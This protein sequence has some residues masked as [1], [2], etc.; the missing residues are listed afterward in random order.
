MNDNIIFK[1]PVLKILIMAT[2]DFRLIV[3]NPSNFFNILK[4]QY[5]EIEFTT[6][7]KNIIIRDEDKN[8][9]SFISIIV[10]EWGN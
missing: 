2:K 1:K 3:D 7:V 8:D 10:E 5:I 4:N 9:N 6:G